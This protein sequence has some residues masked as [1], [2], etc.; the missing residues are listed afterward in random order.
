MPAS[1]PACHAASRAHPRRAAPQRLRPPHLRVKLLQRFGGVPLS[2][3]HK[4]STAA[5]GAGGRAACARAGGA[6]HGQL[7]LEHGEGQL[8]QQGQLGLKGGAHQRLQVLRW[9][10]WA[11]GWR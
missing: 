3:L 7:L 11:V 10:R 9:S 6:A 5:A 1:L 8:A 2:A 4:G